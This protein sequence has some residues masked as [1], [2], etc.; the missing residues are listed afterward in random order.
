MIQKQPE[1]ERSGPPVLSAATRRKGLEGL[2]DEPIDLVVIGAG[3][4]G[5]G[6]ALDAASRG[7]RTVVLEAHDLAF[8]TSRWSSKL[9]H[10]GLRY[11]A[12]GDIGIAHRS[13]VERGILAEHTAPHLVRPL[14]Q[15]VPVFKGA[16][17][18]ALLPRIGFLAGDVLSRLA[19]TPSSILP[20]SRTVSAARTAELVP[21]VR[22]D[23]LRAGFVN[24]DC[25]L[26]DDARLVTSLARTAAAHGASVLTRCRVDS[27]TGDEVTFT[28]TRSDEA[29]TI[30][31]RAVIS[32][33]GVW[34]G[35]LSS[36]IRVRPSR[37]TH[38]VVD[39]ATL[40]HP[41]GALTVPVPGSNSRFCFCLPV[42]NGRV[43]VGLT[44]VDADGQIPDVPASDDDEVDFLL[45]VVSRALRRPLTRA[46]VLGTFAGLR[47]L[48]DGG[49][50]GQTSDLSRRHAIVAD[51]SGLITVTGGKLTEYR[52]MAEQAVDEVVRARGL[53]AGDCMTTRLPL[54]GA[55]G[56]DRLPAADAREL[57]SQ[58]PA[59]LVARF[60]T[61]ASGV[62]ASSL[63]ERPLEAVAEGLDVT[64]AEFSFAC[65][66]EGALDEDDIL[67][68]RSRIGL[69]AAD[70]DAAL[71]A[72][73]EAVTA[74]ASAGR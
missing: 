4:T 30:S 3:V 15:V 46:D 2:G 48:I 6:I 32:A 73:R 61:E 29:H 28:D 23:G 70:R 47:P 53:V 68:R 36:T 21:G 22:R 44:D 39:A 72:A 59:S 50:S 71:P 10:G 42:E 60:G 38:L 66:H 51:P 31:A 56:E 40:G 55:R 17:P 9:A 34:A 63:L 5:T 25:Q 52:L 35:S 19:G 41:T 26:I 54:V 18:G 16:G 33:T 45:D 27:A 65:T 7:L 24:W 69:V 12:S 58:L 1:A 64:R 20:R 14:A 13:A 11:L 43:F 49:E 57:P 37:G 67:D 8:G 74:A 62:V